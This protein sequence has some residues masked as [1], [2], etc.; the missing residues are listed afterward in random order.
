MSLWKRFLQLRLKLMILRHGGWSLFNYVP[1]INHYIIIIRGTL[2]K[3][4]ILSD[5]NKA[6]G[7]YVSVR[8]RFMTPEEKAKSTAE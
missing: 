5:I 7:A 6:T 3:G 8:G 4:P 2:T 1:F